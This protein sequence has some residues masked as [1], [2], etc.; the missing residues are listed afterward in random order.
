M[1]AHVLTDATLFYGG[2][3][4]KGT[5]NAVAMQFKADILDNTV[6]GDTAHAKAGGLTSAQISAK[7]FFDPTIDNVLH[8]DVGAAGVISCAGTAGAE[9]DIAYL[10]RDAV[11]QYDTGGQVGQMLPY[12][13][14]AESDKS[15]VRGILIA[16]KTGQ[17]AGG[18]GTGFVV[19]AVAAGQALSV[20]LHCFAITGGGALTVTVQSDVDNT[21]A[22]PVTVGTFTA[23]SAIGHDWLEITST[24]TDTH[25]RV[26]W[27]L[28]GITPSTDFAV[29][30]GVH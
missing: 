10:V 29:A 8:G 23:L 19:G 4:L 24:N 30:I 9:G 17:T 14:T 11:S 12:S 22:T 6:F 27:T 7:G 13:L 20:A 5:M 16:N 1:T 18:T 26:T 15:L 3:K 2:Y 25:Y 21:F 28:T